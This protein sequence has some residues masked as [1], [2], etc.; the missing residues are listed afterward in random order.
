MKKL[1]DKYIIHTHKGCE[2]K[3]MRLWKKP[4]IS[5]L[6][7]GCLSASVF[8]A[9]TVTDI[10]PEGAAVET[11]GRVAQKE[12]PHKKE[13]VPED[14]SDGAPAAAGRLFVSE[15]V[16]RTAGIYPVAGKAGQY[17]V[18]L[19]E[20]AAWPLGDAKSVVLTFPL[21][22]EGGKSFINVTHIR[23]SL[24]LTL[25]EGDAAGDIVPSSTGIPVL[26]DLTETPPVSGD[27]RLGMVLFWDPDMK[28]DG[29]IH[30]PAA[31]LPVISPT[32]FRIAGTGVTLRKENF[33]DYISSCT[34]AGYSVWPLVDNN[35]DPAETHVFLTDERAQKEAVKT[36]IGYALL[37]K[38]DGY[39][40]DFENVNYADRDRLTRFVADFAAA[41]HAYG[42]RLSMDVTPVSDS[43]NWSKVY[44]RAALAR[45][46]DYMM[47]MAY[48]QVGRT[49]SV[50]GPCASQPWVLKA[51]QTCLPFMDGKKL[52][53]GL[54]LY[55]RLWYSTDSGTDL[56]EDADAWPAVAGTAD[57]AGRFVTAAPATVKGHTLK[58]R[59]L[60]LKD[61]RKIRDKYKDYIRWNEKEQLYY[62]SLPLQTGLV[63]IWFEDEET[64]K[65]KLAL[66]DDYHLGGAAFWRKGF[67]G[68]EF[69][70]YFAPRELT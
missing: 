22:K 10:R 18:F 13:R 60:K 69:W 12:T 40:I 44:D 24:G 62:M 1:H 32:A 27:G 25:A 23:S 14:R 58:V 31:A 65:N 29:N 36:L 6:C 16:L 19:P 5:L 3:F 2:Q 59:T 48:D 8:A 7:W 15:R 53:L 43:E 52:I 64:L 46:L 51:V 56:P 57:G 11:A 66:V 42:I 68:E 45:S 33:D 70:Q 67:E 9:P 54:P 47:L 38:F 4:L 34:Q 20:H 30:K 61:S 37:Y 26:R 55:M 50:A 39:N 63:E 49:S 35:F 28:T 21:V 41:A 17:R